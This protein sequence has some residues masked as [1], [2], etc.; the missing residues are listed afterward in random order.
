M[1]QGSILRTVWL[2]VRRAWR[3]LLAPT[4]GIVAALALLAAVYLGYDV[5]KG[6]VSPCDAIFQETSIGL[7]TRIGFLQTEGAIEIGREAVTELDERAQMTALN[8]KTCCT[9][10]DA[11]RIDPEQFLQCK[12]KARAYDSRL[13]E[14]ADLV[15]KALEGKSI[16]TASTSASAPVVTAAVAHTAADPKI[17]KAVEEAREVSREL[18]K[19]VVEVRKEQALAALEAAPAVHLEI[20]AAEREPNDDVL[21]ANVIELGKLVTAAIGAPGDFDFYT[22]TTPEKFRDWIRIEV[23]NQST[24]LEPA[25]ELFDAAKASLGAVRNTTAGGDVAYEFVAPPKAKFTVRAANYYGKSMGVYLI[26]VVAAKAYDAHEPNDDILSAAAI[27]EGAAVKARIM[28]KDDIDVFR[29]EGGGDAERPVTVKIANA[30]TTLHPN[31]VV[32]DDSKTEVANSRNTTAGGDLTLP[33][34][35]LKGGL[36]VRVS[37]YYAQSGG[38]YT[39]TVAR[40]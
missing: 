23:Q 35:A 20:D 4:G 28:D 9:V 30:S 17:I 39:L 15:E 18:N 34:K 40:E 6:R 38:D 19:T 22:F 25:L 37:D 24:T 12:A 10:L 26:R 29:V 7:S 3:S 32:Y 33:V 16:T 13:E 31:V 21:N 27:K 5:V 36:Y 2:F 1:E 8:L 11:G 14:I